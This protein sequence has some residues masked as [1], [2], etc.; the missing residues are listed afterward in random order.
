VHLIA[1]ERTAQVAADT[2]RVLGVPIAKGL[3]YFLGLPEMGPGAFGCKGS[4]GSIG[5]AD[6]E[7]GFSFA[8]T[9]NRLTAPPA[10]TAAHIASQVRDA[11]AIGSRT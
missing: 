9:H 7:Y 2:D 5:F 10:D 4:G 8:F 1:P 6:P 11:L 3:G